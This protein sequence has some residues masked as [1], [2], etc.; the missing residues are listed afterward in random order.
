M[1]RSDFEAVA[2]NVAHHDQEFAAPDDQFGGPDQQGEARGAAQFAGRQR[3]VRQGFE[4]K[5]ARS[6]ER[7]RR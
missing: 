3:A 1:E 7:R 2:R 5:I 6:C 4:G